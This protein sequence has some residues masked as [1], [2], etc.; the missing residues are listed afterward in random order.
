MRLLAAHHVRPSADASARCPAGSGPRAPTPRS[1]SRRRPDR[2]TPRPASAHRAPRPSLAARPPCRRRR[3]EGG[4]RRRERQRGALRGSLRSR[5]RPRPACPR[6]GASRPAPPAVRPEQP[7]AKAR[8]APVRRPRRRR[9]MPSRSVTSSVVVARHALGL[10]DPL[11]FDRRLQHRAGRQLADDAALDLLPRRL[12]AG[13]L[14]A[15][16][17]RERL[18][19]APPAPRR[20]PGCRPCPG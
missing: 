14:V 8:R 9:R 19:R 10:G 11:V 6:G 18:A 16:V 7:D 2:R 17:G 13:I 4:P 3:R 12:V 1:R 20:R 15:A 5:P